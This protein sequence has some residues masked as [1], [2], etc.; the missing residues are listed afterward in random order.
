MIKESRKDMAKRVKRYIV[1]ESAKKR[2]KKYLINEGIT[3]EEF[4]HR[5]GTSRQYISQIIHGKRTVTEN[6]IMTFHK[7]GYDL[8]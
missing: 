7:G 2:F 4:A 8:I 5:C 6:V 1:T 3:I